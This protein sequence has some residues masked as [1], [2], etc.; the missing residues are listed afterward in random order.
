MKLNPG[1]TNSKQI[2]ADLQKINA[3]RRIL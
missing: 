2:M 3:L 1:G